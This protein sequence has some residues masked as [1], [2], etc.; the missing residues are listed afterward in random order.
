MKVILANPRGFCAGVDR[1]IEIVKKVIKLKGSPIYC[2]DYMYKVDDI[3]TK[4]SAYKYKN[5][6]QIKEQL[7]KQKSILIEEVD[8]S[9]KDLKEKTKKVISDEVKSNLKGKLKGIKKN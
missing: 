4:S 5:W 1:A 9:A 6:D 2:C 7:N 8:K 3:F